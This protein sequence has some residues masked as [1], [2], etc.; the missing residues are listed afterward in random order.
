MGLLTRI[1]API[2]D[3]RISAF[4][5]SLMATHITEVEH[6]YSQMRGWRHDYHSHMQ[7]LKAHLQLQQYEEA[8]AYVTKLADDLQQVDII[9]K[10]GNVMVDAI[11]NSKV[12]IARS[13]GI[14]VNVKAIV[15]PVLGISEIDLC[16][17][18]GNLLDNAI[19]ACGHVANEEERFI[20]IYIDVL[21]KQLYISV[22]NARA[23]EMKR[24]GF[25]FLSTKR[26]SGRGFGL[27]RI[28]AIVDKYG[29]YVNRQVEEG[30]FA[31]EVM[32]PL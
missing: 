17:I 32:L 29:G 15:P 26:A 21:K 10:T 30:V 6:I 18:I 27:I 8:D 19:E 12:S 2:I 4:Q 11:L 28:D 20:R 5:N 16:V 1:L 22:A 25:S 24:S 7:T 23:G 3:K 13:Q 9:I 14:H 31:T